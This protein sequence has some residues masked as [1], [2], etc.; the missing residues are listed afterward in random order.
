VDDAGSSTIHNGPLESVGGEYYP[1]KEFESPTEPE[2]SSSQTKSRSELGSLQFLRRKKSAW[3]DPDDANVKVSLVS[4]KRLRKLRDTTDEDEV[5]GVDYEA[6]L[7]RQYAPV[8]H[9]LNP[10]VNHSL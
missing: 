9:S 6:K 1:G 3:E 7:R 2:Q 4:D 10:V 5:G 8:W